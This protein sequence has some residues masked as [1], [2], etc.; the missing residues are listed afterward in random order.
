MQIFDND[1]LDLGGD[2]GETITVSVET[3]KAQ[4]DLKLDGERFTDETFTLNKAKAD[5]SWLQVGGLFT[6]T[7][8]GGGLFSVTLSGS[9]GPKAVKSVRQFKP[10]QARRSFA[11]VIDIP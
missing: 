5:P 4:V 2:D 11:F 8:A 3:T 7:T 10:A 9:A 1:P 6:D